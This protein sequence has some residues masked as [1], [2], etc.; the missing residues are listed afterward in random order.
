VIL[1]EDSVQ[2][3]KLIDFGIAKRRDP[4]AG[5]IIGRIFAG[6]WG[7]VAPEQLGLFSVEVG[8][9]SDI[10]SLGLVLAEAA[11]GK[12][13]DMGD[14]LETAIRARQ[15]VPNLSQVPAEL[16]PQ[17]AAM[18]QPNPA[19]RPQSI[20][21][22]LQHWPYPPLAGRGWLEKYRVWLISA[23]G[24]VVVTIGITVL[25]PVIQ[26][27]VGF[28]FPCK[29]SL[30]EIM[31]HPAEQVY[32]CARRFYD[33]G[34]KNQLQNALLLWEHTAKQGHGPS[35]LALGTLYDPVLWGKIPSPFSKWNAHQAEKWYK[36]ASEHGARE[37]DIYLQKL[38]S[39]KRK[40]PEG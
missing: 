16:R 3:A 37:V 5:T 38:E 33:T 32:E 24:I 27:I 22:L 8:P 39:W 12:P 34:D 30:A 35:E 6:K 17:L 20:S 23:F 26:R 29:Y 9:Y 13:L 10:Y 4:A 18:L 31:Q 19:D 25:P 36:R 1:P 14:S 40:H 21:K 2:G 28:I 11:I 15:Q 7:Y